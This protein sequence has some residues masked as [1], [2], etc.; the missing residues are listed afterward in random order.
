MTRLKRYTPYVEKANATKGVGAVF[1]KEV[2]EKAEEADLLKIVSEGLALKDVRPYEQQLAQIVSTERKPESVILAEESNPAVASVL[3]DI[4]ARRAIVGV[5]QSILENYSDV[6]GFKNGLEG[7]EGYAKEYTIGGLEEEYVTQELKDFLEGLEGIKVGVGEQGVSGREEFEKVLHLEETLAKEREIKVSEEVKQAVENL[8]MR[9]EVLYGGLWHGNYA[10]IILSDGSVL[11]STEEVEG[12]VGRE[13]HKLGNYIKSISDAWYSY[14]GV[15]GSKIGDMQAI[16]TEYDMLPHLQRLYLRG[17]KEWRKR[18]KPKL[19][20]VLLED[21]M[22]RGKEGYQEYVDQLYKTLTMALILVDVNEHTIQLRGSYIEDSEYLK[23]EMLGVLQRNATRAQKCNILATIPNRSPISKDIVAMTCIYDMTAFEK[24]ILFAH[25]LYTSSTPVKPDLTKTVLGVKFDGSYTMANLFEYR[26]LSIIAGSRSGKGTLTMSMLASLLAN[27][28]GVVYLDNKPDIASLFWNMERS[29]GERG[30]DVKFLAI[31]SSKQKSEFDK[32]VGNRVIRNGDGEVVNIQ[33]V[34]KGMNR[35]DLRPLRTY[36][37]LQMALLLGRI[38]PK[39]PEMD[40]GNTFIFIDEAT[41]LTQ[42]V[43]RMYIALEGGI[44]GKKAEPEL[45]GYCEKI[46]GF[47]SEVGQGFGSI[48]LEEGEENLK[49]VTIGQCLDGTAP[50]DWRVST[51]PALP[52]IGQ[53]KQN[54]FFSILGSTQFWLSGREQVNSRSYRLN[55]EEKTMG[56]KTG[57]FIAHTVKPASGKFAGAAN[58]YAAVEDEITTD[59]SELFRSYFALV[60]NDYSKEKIEGAV[61]AGYGPLNKFLSENKNNGYTYNFLNNVLSNDEGNFQD[62]TFEKAMLELYNGRKIEGVGFEGLIEDI[63]KVSGKGE[64]EYIEGLNTGYNRFNRIFEKTGLGARHGYSCIEE[65]LFD[66]AK[67]SFYTNQE[68]LDMYFGEGEVG[69]TGKN[70]GGLVVD[71]DTSEY[72]DEVDE[73]EGE[74]LKEIQQETE[75][76]D[77]AVLD[78]DQKAEEEKQEIEED[79]QDRKDEANEIEDDEEREEVL[80]EIDEDYERQQREIEEAK[81]EEKRELERQKQELAEKKAELE[82]QKRE[83]EAKQAQAKN[84]IPSPNNQGVGGAVYN[85]LLEVPNNPFETYNTDKWGGQLQSY[86]VMEELVITDIAKMIGGL[87]RMETFRMNGK[88]I[89]TVNDITYTPTF[90][91]G[92][93]E[94]VPFALRGKLEQGILTDLFDFRHLLGAKG[95]QSLEIEHLRVARG[96]A[97]QQLGLKPRQRYSVLFDRLPNLYYINVAGVEYNQDG[98][99]TET[100]SEGSSVY[101]EQGYEEREGLGEKMGRLFGF[102]RNERGSYRPSPIES[103]AFDAMMQSRPVRII[104]NAAGWTIGIKAVTVIAGLFGGWGL[105]F[106][107]LA[108][109]GAYNELSK[110]SQ[111]GKAPSSSRGRTN[112]SDG[113]DETDKPKRKRK[114]E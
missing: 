53:P 50:K 26:F 100:A 42:A 113:Y 97:R 31:D 105:V 41:L 63:V 106:G 51:T 9:M 107:G 93:M 81:E 25:K 12:R 79:Y 3:E 84:Q 15:E 65:Y 34:P 96:P 37:F 78:V 76:L 23:D 75:E 13:V 73:P 98:P 62:G 111:R 8:L 101:E 52:K 10:G 16:N 55:K 57:A 14:T 35:L 54:L 110:G 108:A 24:E 1:F 69:G 4:V 114:K 72:T 19:K 44:K 43:E 32:A 86:R 88:G 94:T 11:Y 112:Q 20:R 71:V 70:Q 80:Q 49:F 48:S 28:E 109:A 67:D 6:E 60:N 46:I 102:G 83:K 58:I 66:C 61:N 39:D 21:L 64:D 22:G 77:Q 90:D 38:R 99:D 56:N 33:N 36:K 40:K 59:N 92:F 5:W 7:K 103:P 91:A 17:E 27:G 87:E 95:L 85:E 45:A 82:R 2:V 104:T 29:M 68:I 47:L 18:H 30:K 74:E 89:I